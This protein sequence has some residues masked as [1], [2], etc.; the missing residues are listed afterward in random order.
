MA[1]GLFAAELRRALAASEG[2]LAK[3]RLQWWRET[4]EGIASERVRRHDLSEELARVYAGRP[5]LNALSL[6][7]IDRFEDVLDDHL[8]VGHKATPE[9]EMLHVEQEA[10]LNELSAAA[11]AGP[12]TDAERV[13][14]KAVSA[15]EIARQLESTSFAEKSKV[16][17]QAGRALG[18]ERW[19]AI[20]QYAGQGRSPLSMRWRILCAVSLRKL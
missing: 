10:A 17:A 12:L 18:S 15:A 16:A 13:A 4:L 7:L 11:A 14:L 5:D 2:M 20:A 6:E 1:V 8:H 9:H 19:P 3:I